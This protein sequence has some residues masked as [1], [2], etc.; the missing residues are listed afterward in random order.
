VQKQ[1]VEACLLKARNV[2]PEKQP[3]LA[4][5][6]ET[7]FVWWISKNES[8]EEVMA[9]LKLLSQHVS[10]GTVENQEENWYSVQN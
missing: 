6:S 5:G 7:T 3:F 2:E 10:L 9:D 4:N 8:K 1:N